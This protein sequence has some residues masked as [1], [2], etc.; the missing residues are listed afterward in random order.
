MSPIQRRDHADKSL[1]Q[2]IGEITAQENR[3]L[4]CKFLIAFI[5]YCASMGLYLGVLVGK[6]DDN[7]TVQGLAFLN[8]LFILVSDIVVLSLRE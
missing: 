3:N 5:A 4:C 6:E 8:P 1:S 7:D 2:T